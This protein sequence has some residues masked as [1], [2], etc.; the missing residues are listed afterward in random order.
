VGIFWILWKVKYDVGSTVKIWERNGNFLELLGGVW[1]GWEWDWKG[2]IK[3]RT[4][5]KRLDKKRTDKKR[6]D[7]KRTDKKG[8]YI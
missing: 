6:T 4:D 8:P 3:K 5:K 2:L 1:R 7:K